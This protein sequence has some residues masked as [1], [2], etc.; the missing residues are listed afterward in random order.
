MGILSPVLALA[1]LALII[2]SGEA[3]AGGNTVQDLVPSLELYKASDTWRVSQGKLRV[4]KLNELATSILIETDP[5]SETKVIFTAPDVPGEKRFL[6]MKLLA[7][8]RKVSLIT[9]KEESPEL[10]VPRGGFG[11]FVLCYSPQ[12]INLLTFHPK[13]QL[14]VPETEVLRAKYPV[15]DV[16][17]HICEDPNATPQSRLEIMDAV[18]VAIVIDSPLTSQGN[19]TEESYRRFQSQSPKR[20]M[21]FASVDV[22]NHEEKGFMDKVVATLKSDV[23]TFG[24][25]GIAEMIDKGCGF[26]RLSWFPDPHGSLFVD[27]E[28]LS[29][30]W[31]AITELHLPVLLHVT[32]PAGFDLDPAESELVLDLVS[33][34]WYSLHDLPAYSRE[35]ML[36]RRDVLLER[37]P[38]LTVIS[39]HIDNNMDNLSAVAA[40]LRKFPNLYMEIGMRHLELAQQPRTARKFFEEFQ[41]RIL[42]GA[43]SLEEMDGY[44]LQFR[45]FETEDDAIIRPFEHNSL[46][47]AYGLGLPDVILKKLYYANA[48]KVIPHV[49]ENLL[50]LYPGLDFPQ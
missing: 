12:N 30:L 3:S 21:T 43:D 5:G 49:K 11:W 7:T 23:K 42:F 1:L 33:N 31:Q 40:R 13:R 37:F 39:A 22:A 6:D 26:D 27:S 16:H 41:D 35:E 48:A 46:W 10:T 24:P 19:F 4:L 32:D 44:R 18:G 9:S 8:E 15:V 50:A 38:N 14:K 45:I 47:P 36:R 29:P 25:V 20:F 28:A 2:R 34:P 17:A